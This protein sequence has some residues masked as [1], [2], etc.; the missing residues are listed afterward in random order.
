V[1]DEPPRGMERRMVH[2]LLRHWRDA[3]VDDALPSLD[4][5]YDQ[6]IGDIVPQ[7]FVVRIISEDAEPVLGRIGAAF[8]DELSATLGGAPLSAVPDATLMAMTA[9][10]YR[11]VLK[12]RVPITRGDSFLH[13]NGDTWLYRSV[14]VPAS[15]DGQSIHFLLCAAN[16][17]IV[18]D[19]GDAG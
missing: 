9:G 18:A 6:R 11:E 1:T 14:I 12:R 17:K 3:R 7:S 13:R 19:R 8:E 2:R 15:A 4:A 10:F 16:G 5:V